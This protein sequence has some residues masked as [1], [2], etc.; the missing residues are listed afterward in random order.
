MIRAFGAHCQ[1]LT[2]A[3]EQE[4]ALFDHLVGQREQLCR[5]LKPERFACLQ[6]DHK[7]QFRCLCYRQIVRFLAC[8]MRPT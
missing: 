5:Q 8:E 2:H 4:G 3:L 7:L 1:N 6:V